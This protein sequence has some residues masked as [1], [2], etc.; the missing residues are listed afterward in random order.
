MLHPKVENAV[1]TLGSVAP[2]IVRATD[3]ESFLAGQ[4]LTSETIARTAE[5]AKQAANPID[6][7]RAPATYRHEIVRVSVSRCLKAILN[8]EERIGFPEKPVVLWGD[9]K[10]HDINP[11]PAQIHHTDVTPITTRI[12]G[13]TYTFSTGQQKTLLRLLREEAGLIGTKE[14]CA[15]GECGACTIFLDGKAVMSCL[16]PAVRAHQAEIITIEGVSKDGKLHPVQQAFIDEGAVQCGY[17]TPGFIM[18][19]VKLLE[20]QPHPDQTEIK[21]SIT[22]NLCRC[23]GYYKIIQAIERASMTE[24]MDG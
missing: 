8:R 9:R 4:M 2:T 13:R 16:V 1:I 18:S 12:N 5:L 15:E 24:G 23:T 6:D 22:G 3:A 7:I 10:N 20:E 17:C 11:L 19:A 14:G 21:H